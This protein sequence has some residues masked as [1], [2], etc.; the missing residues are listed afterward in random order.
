MLRKIFTGLCLIVAFL[1]QVTL[2]QS[3]SLASTKPNLILILVFIF[4][5]MRGQ[6][7][8][9][10]VGF[11]GGLLLD[12]YYG[13]SIGFYAMIYMY[14]GYFNGTFYKLFYDEDITL[15]LLL[16][17]VSNILYGFSVYVIRFLLRGRL[18]FGYY[19][20]H[21]IIAET[22]YTMIVAILIYRPIL[23]MNRVLE[24]IEKRSASKFG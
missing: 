3:L 21:V 15:P 8:G 19:V 20:E 1:L 14:I 7:T 5:F 4:G 2:F 6:K 18:D 17:F 11:L 23:K 10:W 22:I 24:K 16:I 13:D 12:I 9:I